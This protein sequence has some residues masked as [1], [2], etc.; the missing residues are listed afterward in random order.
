MSSL[1]KLI[2]VSMSG[3]LKVSRNKSRD[4]KMVPWVI[5]TIW[6]ACKWPE[7]CSSD[8]TYQPRVTFS[9]TSYTVE[10]NFIDTITVYSE[11]EPWNDQKIIISSSLK[12]LFSS[13]V[14]LFLTIL[15]GPLTVQLKVPIIQKSYSGVEIGCLCLWCKLNKFYLD[16]SSPRSL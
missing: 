15:N 3:S 16:V 2:K 14:R 8:V 9:N 1:V 5:S 7:P 11:F 6:N 13:I 10:A 12:D 4:F